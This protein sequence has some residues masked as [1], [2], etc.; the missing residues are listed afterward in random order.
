MNTDI[1]GMIVARFGIHPAFPSSGSP[2]RPAISSG[3]IGGV[4]LDARRLIKEMD[5]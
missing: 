1:H 5:F 2:F 3:T 4:A